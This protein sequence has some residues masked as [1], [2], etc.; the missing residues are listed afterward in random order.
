MLRAVIVAA[1]LL[2]G[3]DGALPDSG[4]GAVGD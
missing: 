4:G 1:P 2:C 3:A